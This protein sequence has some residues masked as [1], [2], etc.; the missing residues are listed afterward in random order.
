MLCKCFVTAYACVN[1]DVSAAVDSVGVDVTKVAYASLLCWCCAGGMNVLIHACSFPL[2]SVLLLLDVVIHVC[3]D[4][5]LFC[6]V[7]DCSL[8]VAHPFAHL[9]GSSVLLL[10]VVVH[11]SLLLSLAVSCGL[12]LILELLCL[13]V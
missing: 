5:L 1:A 6:D 9:L 3:S 7:A 11:P 12:L 4:P 2:T 10:F 8:G 13:L